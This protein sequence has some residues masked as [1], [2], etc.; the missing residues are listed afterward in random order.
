M[1]NGFSRLKN[2]STNYHHRLWDHSA[3]RTTA[4][5]HSKHQSY[6]VLSEPDETGLYFVIILESGS[7]SQSQKHVSSPTEMMATDPAWQT[8]PDVLPEL[9]TSHME[10]TM[11][12]DAAPAEEEQKPLEQPNGTKWAASLAAWQKTPPTPVKHLLDLPVDILQMVI[13]EASALLFPSIER[14]A[15][16]GGG[17][18]Y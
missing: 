9:S 4:R 6:A 13:K 17:G 2:T 10:D 14:V 3:R 5:I 16:W 15:S 7:R 8:P 18:P 12:P 11:P 1:T